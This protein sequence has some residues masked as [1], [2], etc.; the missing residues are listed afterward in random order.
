MTPADDLIDRK[1][2]KNPQVF[3]YGDIHEI[4]QNTSSTTGADDGASG[5]LHKTGV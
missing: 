1:P 4:T 3:D 5:G 2:Y